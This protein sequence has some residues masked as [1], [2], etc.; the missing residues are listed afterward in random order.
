M[1]WGTHTAAAPVCGKD[2]GF[3]PWCALVRPVSPEQDRAEPSTVI[4]VI[5]WDRDRTVWE[6]LYELLRA[7]IED[8]TYRPR[9]P[10]PS[11]TQLEQEFEV[12]RTTVRRVLRI[13]KDEGYLRAISGKGTF[14]RPSG[15]WPKRQS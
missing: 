7:R 15:D 5:E 9:Y 8:G 6:Q 13:L 1:T 10:I 4:L 3:T 14:V 12:A 11:I 2:G